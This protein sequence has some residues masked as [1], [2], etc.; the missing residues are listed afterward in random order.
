MTYWHITYL[1][2]IVQSTSG[3][4]DGYGYY[5]LLGPKHWNMQNKLIITDADADA[6]S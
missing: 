5:H 1:Y 3:N 2:A 4:D 6:A